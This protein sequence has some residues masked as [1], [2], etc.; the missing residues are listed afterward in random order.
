MSSYKI[1]IPDRLSAPAD[2]EQ[3]VFGP[4]AQIRLLQAK[5]TNEVKLEDW[6]WADAILLW[7]DL[8]LDAALLANCRACKSIVRVGAGFDNVDIA[9]AAQL[10]IPVCNV[11]DYGVDDVAD[12]ALSFLVSLARGLPGLDQAA[13]AG[14]WDWD[15]AKDFKRITHSV[16]GIIGLGRIGTAVAMRARSFGLKVLFYDPYVAR[17]IEKSLSLAR[18][19]SLEEI[20]QC[21]DFISLHVPLSAETTGM[22][23]ANFF[24]SCSKHP[25]IINTAR[26][27]VLDLNALYEGLKSGNI[28]AAG[29]DVLDV[30]PPDLKHPLIKAWQK[31]EDW[32]EGR[33]LITPHS[34]FCNR[35]S[36]LEIRTKAAK[37]ALRAL[38]SKPL[39]YCVNAGLLP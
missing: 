24:E 4:D 3:E 2:V 11:P 15:R 28:A 22:L 6:K 10:G 12:H 37:E 7:H 34:A 33:I 13:R 14:T 39:Y 30:E 8:H 27:A 25:I 1:L 26:G 29:M 32:L 38:T 9:A 21:S 18:A 23:D 16:L 35:E 20:A 17:G 31:R 36:L 5:Q 19:E